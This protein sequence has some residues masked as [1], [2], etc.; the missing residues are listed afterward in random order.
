MLTL[1][2]PNRKIVR[3]G[4]VVP[5]EADIGLPGCNVSEHKT[6]G[7]RCVMARAR[8]WKCSVNSNYLKVQTPE[9]ET[10]ALGTSE[11]SKFLLLLVALGRN[12]GY[13]FRTPASDAVP[14][15]ELLKVPSRNPTT[16]M[17]L[18]FT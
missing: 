10:P 5:C 12:D 2:K 9:I 17:I 3:L 15:Y 1:A 16:N 18:C 11:E 8:A 13:D 6:Q 7:S 4:A 14:E